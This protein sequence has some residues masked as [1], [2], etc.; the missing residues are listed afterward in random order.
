MIKHVVT[1]TPAWGAS[2]LTSERTCVPARALSPHEH[3]LP[4]PL[5]GE[6][7][8]QRPQPAQIRAASAGTR[9]RGR[10]CASEERFLLTRG[11]QVQLY[12]GVGEHA[13]HTSC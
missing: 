5:H 4:L 2:E 13:N 11:E 6:P 9:D 1:C 12:H 10:Q 8:H 7:Q 3:S